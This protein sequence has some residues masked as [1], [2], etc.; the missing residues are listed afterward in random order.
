MIGQSRLLSS[1]ATLRSA[2]LTYSH[3][4]PCLSASQG[5]RAMLGEM[6]GEGLVPSSITLCA[7]LNAYGH[8]APSSSTP[9]PSNGPS[10]GQGD[11][12]QGALAAMALFDELKADGFKLDSKVYSSLMHILHAAGMH[13]EVTRTRTYKLGDPI[14]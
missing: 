8:H 4:S 5:A 9:V 13:N 11:K 7:L 6:L 14:I 3:F 1:D 10:S 2:V 12:R